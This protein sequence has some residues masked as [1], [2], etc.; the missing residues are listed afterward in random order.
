MGATATKPKHATRLVEFVSSG[1]LNLSIDREK[2][3]VR[4]VKILGL[5]S[6]NGRTYSPSAVRNAARLYEGAKVNV[7]HPHGRADEPRSYGDRLGSLSNVVYREGQGLFGDFNYNPKHPIAEQFLHDAEHAPGNVGL[8]H[9]VKARLAR[10]TTAGKPVVEQIDH[11]TS[12]DLVADPATTSSLYESEQGETDMA[13]ESVTLDQLLTERADLLEAWD[14]RQKDSDA[15]KARD[16][17]VKVLREQ[18]D[19]LQAEKAAAAIRE[20]VATLIAEAKLP[21]AMVTEVFRNSLL[22]AKDDAARKLLIEDRQAVA[23]AATWAKPKSSEQ[24]VT[25]STAPRRDVKEA[26]AAYTRR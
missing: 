21:A 17:E 5:E 8:S 10:G 26:V 22:E 6:K 15:A 20:S 18:L 9:N 1:G 3:V 13:L 2:A 12:V 16:A 19:N 4:G 14:A 7:D 11:V 25:E 24:Q 23:K